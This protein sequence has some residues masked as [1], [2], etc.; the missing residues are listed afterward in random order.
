MQSVYAR[1]PNETWKTSAALNAKIDFGWRCPCFELRAPWSSERRIFAPWF[2][3]RQTVICLFCCPKTHL[4][5]GNDDAHD[6][7]DATCLAI[8]IG[9]L[10]HGWSCV[11]GKQK[12]TRRNKTFL[13]LISEAVS[14]ALP[15]TPSMVCC[16]RIYDTVIQRNRSRCNVRCLLP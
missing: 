8:Y 2:H 5:S 3:R 10:T 6:A 16:T 9:F 13:F 14:D 1:S 15:C 4:S 12:K 7:T 11:S